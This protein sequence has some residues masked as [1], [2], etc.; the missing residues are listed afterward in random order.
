MEVG[1]LNRVGFIIKQAKIYIKYDFSFLWYPFLLA[2]RD[3][4][5]L[6]DCVWDV[7]LCCF[8][9]LSVSCLLVM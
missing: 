4:C 5:M 2:I 9:V 7:R 8:L 6:S 1:E 3:V